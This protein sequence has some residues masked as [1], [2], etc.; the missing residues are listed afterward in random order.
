MTAEHTAIP[1]LKETAEQDVI[2]RARGGDE[3]AFRLLM[4]R[5]RDHAFAIALRITRSPQDAEDVVQQAF[6]RAWHALGKFRADSTFRTWLHRIV[7]RRALDRA[8]E[9]KTRR[10][11]EDDTADPAF[12]QSQDESRDV[13]L[14]RRLELLMQQL[15]PAQR[16]VVTLYYWE[17]TSVEEIADA[18]RMPENTV[19]TH[20]SRARAALREAWLRAER[21]Q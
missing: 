18:L 12:V 5:H 20:L 10:E 16:A 19:K 14:I 11:R 4:N 7:A 8:T 13:L 6:V 9:L 1:R 15:T 3:D 2:A 21:Q 17:E